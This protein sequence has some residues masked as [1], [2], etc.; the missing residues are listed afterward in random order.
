MGAAITALSD[1]ID[2]LRRNPVLL[3]GAVVTTFIVAAGM[4]FSIV[5]L[6]GGL[7]FQLVVLPIALAGMVS[8]TDA[9]ATGRATFGDFSSGIGVHS[10]SLMGAYA[11]MLL[12][13]LGVVVF[14]V[15][16]MFGIGAGALASVGAAN[17]D[18]GS[19]FGALGGAMLLVLLLGFLAVLL[20]GLVRQFLDVT[21]VV[22]SEDASGALGAAFGLVVD[23]PVS[24]LGY[25]LLRVAVV[26]LGLLFPVGAGA[27]LVIAGLEANSAVA[28]LFGLVLIAIAVPVA[29]VVSFAYHVSYYRRLTG[30]PVGPTDPA[31]K[32][33]GG[34]PESNTD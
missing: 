13:Q 4:V 23:N 29:V 9:G 30:L 25:S 5:P 3:V 26:G 33:H 10:V 24:V 11:L 21:V 6:V 12:L 19:M 28:P 8:M 15:L 31:T 22:G 1:S 18:P 20:V 16:A 32:G 34:R 2:L 14:V 17:G 27:W 7:V